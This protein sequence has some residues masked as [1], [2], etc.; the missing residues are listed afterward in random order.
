QKEKKTMQT[1]NF[2]FQ[3]KGAQYW[4]ARI[5]ERGIRT[6]DDAVRYFQR[7]HG[8][9]RANAIVAARKSRPDLYNQFHAH[10]HRRAVQAPSN[11]GRL[12]SKPVQLMRASG[13]PVVTFRGL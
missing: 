10:A 5:E 13:S 2:T 7:E 8:L 6:F 12:S 3:N 11:T 4:A 9:S 1:Q